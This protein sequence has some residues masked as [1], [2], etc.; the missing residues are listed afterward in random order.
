ME[1]NLFTIRG[2]KFSNK[3]VKQSTSVIQIDTVPSLY[4]FSFPLESLLLFILHLFL[5]L[6]PTCRQL[7]VYIDTYP[8]SLLQKSLGDGYKAE[9]VLFRGHF[10]INAVRELVTE[11]SMR[12]Q[13][14]SLR[15]SQFSFSLNIQEARPCHW[16]FLEGHFNHQE[17]YLIYV[18]LI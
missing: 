11:H 5:H 17:L 2:G 1:L 12:W 6:Y 10:L 18:Q 14:I 7:R 9:K 15:Y 13:Q 3:S 16:S 4:F 8:I